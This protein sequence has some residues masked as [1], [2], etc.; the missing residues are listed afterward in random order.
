MFHSVL[1]AILA[2]T[3]E[4]NEDNYDC[5]VFS[6]KN[7]SSTS[8]V[9]KTTADHQKIVPK[10]VDSAILE[11][12]LACRLIPLDENPRVRPPDVCEILR[13]IAGKVVVAATCNDVI[14]NI[15]FLQ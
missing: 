8:I 6:T 3:D 15:G 1:N 4:S 13:W 7:L 2:W 12:W 10:K 14:T 5:Y 11:A 9:C